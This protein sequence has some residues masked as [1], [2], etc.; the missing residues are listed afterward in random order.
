MKLK[1]L[2]I[3]LFFFINIS[4]NAQVNIYGT[5]KDGNN[6]PLEFVNII[7]YTLAD[8][9]FLGG[10]VSELDGSFHV[11]CNAESD[12][13]ILATMINYDDYNSKV[14]S[15]NILGDDI[16]LGI[17]NLENLSTLLNEVTVTARKPIFQQKADRLII[18]VGNS[19]LSSSQSA[20]DVLERSPGVTINRQSGLISLL[21]KDGVGIM[22]DGKVTN[23]PAEGVVQMLAGMDGASIEKIEL[24]TTPPSQLDS[25]GNG[26]FINI[27]FKE[28]KIFG[29]SASVSMSTGYGN[30]FVSSANLNYNYLIGKFEFNSN[31]SINI[32][33]QK[34]VFSNYRKSRLNDTIVEYDTKSLRDPNRFNQSL[35]LAMDY[36]FTKR[37]SVGVFFSGYLNRWRMTAKN[38]VNIS[39]NREVV[40]RVDI[41]NNETN[42]W[43]HFFGSANFKH[44]F[45]K[46]FNFNFNL[47]IL[48]YKNENPN[49]YTNTFLTPMGTFDRENLQESRKVTPIQVVVGQV[50]FNLIPTD[51]YIIKS[52]VKYTHSSF[53]NVVSVR[54]KKNTDWVLEKEL[55][56]QF[57]LDEHIGAAYTTLEASINA[58]I[59]LN[60]GFRYEYSETKLNKNNATN[61]VDRKSHNVFPNLSA[62]YKFNDF[63]QLTIGFSRRIVRPRF[64]D[65]AP[66]TIFLD[67][68]TLFTGNLTLR[69][70]I[71]RVFSTSFK[72]K[73]FIISLN[74]NNEDN[75]IA[76][77]QNTIN[78]DSNQQLVGAINLDHR[79]T[80]SLSLNY[81]T[82]LGKSWEIQNNV[83]LIN[84]SAI[85]IETSGFSNTALT[86][87]RFTTSQNFKIN[88]DFLIELSG[89]YNSKTLY[90]LSTLN[91]MYGIT[92]GLQKKMGKK[93]SISFIVTDAFNSIEE[94]STTIFRD[95]VTFTEG[96]FDYSQRTFR[97]SFNH[98]FGEY[99]NAKKRSSASEIEQKR[100][101]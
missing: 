101:R 19:V 53:E 77:N 90:G 45:S 79:K 7:V 60:V 33:N 85:P 55:S 92:L 44:E 86:Y 46:I 96:F 73:Q 27:V 30:G 59:K 23:M 57:E 72:L 25:E 75:A 41:L 1:Y 28:K 29:H 16:N 32:E 11:S 39:Q 93:S 64:N 99:S 37:T 14:L 51:K 91:S 35:R 26:G 65:L 78:F 95:N 47:D 40:S 38:E 34:Q 68:N 31:Y 15:P 21:G 98:R 56:D 18:N 17:I 24:I 88:R 81:S 100:V 52:G 5:I 62:A 9:I 3:V 42:L 58:K 63:T 71:I 61:L 4:L 8:S 76:R 74:Y 43:N 20:I 6:Q 66:F 12:I 84:Q 82:F 2:S 69:P 87:Y 94:L 70:A 97:L 48:K 10:T 50:D 54:T 13:Y 89:F 36:K 83:V 80:F 67:P 49:D 22:L